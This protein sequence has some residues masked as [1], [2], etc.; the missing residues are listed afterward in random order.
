M[1]TIQYSHNGIVWYKKKVT[2]N[3]KDNVRLAS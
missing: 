1:L 2:D 3:T